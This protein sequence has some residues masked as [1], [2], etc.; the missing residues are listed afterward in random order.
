LS[1]SSKALRHILPMTPEGTRVCWW[2]KPIGVSS[3][4]LG[5]QCTSEVVL[6]WPGRLVAPGIRDWLRAMPARS[7]GTLPGRKP[8]AFCVW[9]FQLLGAQPGDTLDDLFPGTGG[10]GR[11]WNELMCRSRIEAGTVASTSATR[12]DGTGDV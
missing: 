10:V 3:K 7:G 8:I 1:T 12:A 9:M 6:V 11:A 5:L 2:G 4:A